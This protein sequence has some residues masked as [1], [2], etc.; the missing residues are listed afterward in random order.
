MGTPKKF[1]GKKEESPKPNWSHYTE[2]ECGPQ[3]KNKIV[4][5]TI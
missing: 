1:T 3:A 4:L 2:N 5:D